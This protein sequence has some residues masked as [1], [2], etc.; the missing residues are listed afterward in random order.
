MTCGWLPSIPAITEFVVPRSMPT[1]L[2]MTTPSPEA[3]V[4]AMLLGAQVTCIP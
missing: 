4:T 3:L 2:P 1:A